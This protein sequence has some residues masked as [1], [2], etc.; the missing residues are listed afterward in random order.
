VENEAMLEL[1]KANEQLRG[2][3][4]RHRQVEATLERLCESEARIRREL[5]QEISDSKE[6]IRVLV[7]ELKSPVSSMMAA[8][9]ILMDRLP[10]GALRSLAR[11]LSRGA[12][13]LNS[14]VDELIDLARNE[15][16]I[17]RL[18]RK[19]VDPLAL[20]RK[21]F[22][23]MA[24]AIW[25][26]EQSIT[27]NTPPLLPTVY[28]D[29]GRLYQVIVNLLQNS[30]KF[31]PAGGQIILRAREHE[32]SLLV[33]VVDSGPGIA[34]EDQQRLFEPYYRVES[35]GRRVS[36]LGLGL[37]LCKAL[38]EMHGGR[39]WVNSRLGEGSVFGFSV[40]LGTPA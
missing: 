39:I 32:G 16:G 38:V 8:C 22:D 30:S 26:R 21:V 7:H 5:E 27:L 15:V 10:E 29:E 28:A 4:E 18:E 2:E 14:R 20:L 34:E 13:I 19:P 3:L 33:E 6:F 25:N 17:L 11:T 40:P 35:N 23:D 12:D 24:P 31:T 9:E 37:T 1:R 36:G